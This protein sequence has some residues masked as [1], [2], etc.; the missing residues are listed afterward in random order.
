MRVLAVFFT[1]FGIV[2][3]L[4]SA[5]FIYQRTNLN[6][7][8]FSDFVQEGNE[9]QDFGKT[10]PL[11]ITLQTLQKTLPIF[12]ASASKDTWQ[13]SA[14]GIS[15]LSTSPLPGDKG[16][17]ILYGHN[18]PNLLGA[19]SKMKPGDQISIAFTDGSVREFVVAYTTTVNPDQVEILKSSEDSRLTLYTCTGFL[20]SN[21]F[22]VTAKLK[23]D[24]RLKI[25]DQSQFQS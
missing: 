23:E 15:Y 10:Q 13:T 12:P 17:S 5:Y 6:N 22:V 25:K 9:G 1:I 14:S 20:D 4:L 2:C 11:A 19:L 7:L 16:N 3:L 24:Q 8:A 18:W 21:R